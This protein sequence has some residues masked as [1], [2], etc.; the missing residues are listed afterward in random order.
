MDY[1]NQ[2][3]IVRLSPGNGEVT[4]VSFEEA[5]GEHSN[6]RGRG[7]ARRAAKKSQKQAVRVNKRLTRVANRGAVKQARR[8]N[9]QAKV[10]DKIYRKST[11]KQ[12]RLDKRALGQEEEPLENAAPIT[13][14]ED[15]QMQDSNANESAP[16]TIPQSPAE[17]GYDDEE[18]GYDG[19]EDEYTY[20]EGGDDEESESDSEFMGEEANSEFANENAPKKPLNPKVMAIGRQIEVNSYIL[21]CLNQKLGKGGDDTAIRAEIDNRN[22]KLAELNNMI[23]A[24]S[25][26]R[27]G[28]HG[29]GAQAAKREV[30]AARKVARKEL[31]TQVQAKRAEKKAIKQEARQAAR[32]AA[33][34]IQ[35]P[36]TP[37]AA[38]LDPSISDNRIEI[39]AEEVESSFNGTGIIAIDEEGDFDAPETRE[40]EVKSGFDGGSIKKLP[41][42]K[43]AIGVA[44][45]GVILYALNKKKII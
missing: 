40:V 43:I 44:V 11:R 33:R 5:F 7:R 34:P 23:E 20:D 32:P 8:A 25:E 3:T 31:R 10:E 17:S 24:Y 37:V 29:G 6:L 2:P 45:A 13:Q 1:D 26:A 36:V 21:H 35:R 19:E 30:R 27:G 22:T 39:P 18:A 14:E 9:R 12:G 41:W 38:N 42:G 16:R 4:S 28:R 15:A